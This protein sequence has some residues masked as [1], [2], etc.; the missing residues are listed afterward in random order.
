MAH[1]EIR[2]LGPFEVRSDGAPVTGFETDSARG[3]LARLAAEPGMAHPRPVLAEM[4]W[5]DRPPGGARANLRHVLSV[6]RRV[7]GDT[8]A[9]APVVSADRSW[10]SLDPGADVW[11]DVV[12]FERLASTAPDQDGAEEAW[13]RAVELWRGPFLEGLELRAGAAWDEWS[14]VT[15]ERL[16]R[17]LAT[18]LGH[19]ADRLERAG[20]PTEA[21]LVARRL[22]EVDPWDERAHRQLLRVLAGSGGR[23]QALAA[24][25]AFERRLADELGTA[26]TSETLALVD[27]IR[28]D[29][30]SGDDRADEI[31]YP[32]FL[33]HAAARP[34][35]PFAGRERELTEL[36]RE[37]DAAVAGHGRIVFIAGEAGSGKT[38]LA[39]ELVRRATGHPDL[40]VA[41]GRC[42]AIGGLGDPYLPFRE[43]LELLCG[44]VESSLA[45]GTLTREHATRLWETIPRTVRLLTE[46]GPDLIDVMVDGPRLA[47]RVGEAVPGARW[48]PD[49]VDRLDRLRHRELRRPQPALFDEYTAVLQ[50]LAVSH[51]LLVVVDDLQWADQGSIALLWH[52]ARRLDGMRVLLVALYRPEEVVPA[53]DGTRALHAVLSELQAADGGAVVRPVNDRAFVDEL[54]D[55]EPNGLDRAFR[56]RLFSYTAGHPLFTVEMVRGMKER[57][58]VRRDRAG[59]WRVAA[60]LDWERLPDRVE[61]AIAQRLG[62]LPEELRRDLDMG[63]VQGPEFLDEVVA[64]VRG[65]PATLA[66]LAASGSPARGITEDAGASRIGGR[67]VAR[68]RFR[69]VLFQRYLYDHLGDAA[70][71]RSHEATARALLELYGADPDLPVVQLAHHFDAAGLVEPAIDHLQRA[72]QRAI[73]MSGTEEAIHLLERALGL[74]STRPDTAGRDERELALLVALSGPVMAAEGYGAPE[75]ERIGVR[76]LELC[77]R[78]EPSSTTAMARLGMASVLS[79]R[80]EYRRSVAVSRTALATSEELDDDALRAMSHWHLGHSLLFMGELSAAHESFRRV[81]DR[82]DPVEHAWLTHVL[83]GAPGPQALAWDSLLLAT[84]GH[85]DRARRVGERAIA[86]AREIGH[87]FTLCHALAA[88]GAVRPLTCGQHDEVGPVIDEVEAIARAEHFP[89]YAVAADLYRGQVV[90]HQGDPAAGRDIIRT[91]LDAWRAMGIEAYRAHW[92][93]DLAEFEAATGHPARALELLDDAL[94]QVAAT[95]ER[96]LEGDLLLQRGRLLMGS[97][98]AGAVGALEGAR[99]SARAMGH[100]L[101]ELRALTALAELHLEG[102]DR[103]RATALLAPAYASF[104]EGLGTPHLVAARRVLDRA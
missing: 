32:S 71:L 29:E 75:A 86:A 23:A 67:L 20:E 58:E 79:V 11:V 74:L 26:P 17:R 19:L 48:L 2:L 16:R 95:G 90:G 37:L 72:G 53:A 57:T 15:S 6:L 41:R 88:A 94:R 34:R 31:A 4:L 78:L 14:V 81:E 102:G 66:R 8:A 52:L 73:E 70:R 56:D 24:H 10:V 39:D 43:V 69:H 35:A 83:G 96:F 55:L 93:C 38:T 62:R 61:A 51:P 82:Y 27:R 60:S 30:Q 13:R 7:L 89:F 33:R 44:D 3:L 99:R 65:E 63:S 54:L 101:G 12:E 47:E 21:A 42:N 92:I 98:R 18:A 104:D 22:T 40:L 25:E 80:A 103:A 49:L 46:A 9:S 50:R 91:G 1:I 64:A 36:H 68:H 45:S 97:D 84:Q 100:R 59:V 87:P 28:A 5:P 85:L 76:V 77:D